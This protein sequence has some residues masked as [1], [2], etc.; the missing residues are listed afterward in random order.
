MSLTDSQTRYVN[1]HTDFA[2]KKIFGTEANKE[3]LL[4]FLNSFMLRGE[5]AFP[6]HYL[7]QSRTAGRKRDR[8]KGWLLGL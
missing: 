6:G 5:R 8:P 1:F 4:S 7:P 2:F 3:L